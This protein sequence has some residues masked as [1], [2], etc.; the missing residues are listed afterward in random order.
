MGPFMERYGTEK[1]LALSKDAF[2]ECSKTALAASARGVSD[3]LC[4][5]PPPQ[6]TSRR[7]PQRWLPHPAQ[8][9]FC[10]CLNFVA[11]QVAS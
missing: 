9:A 5:F 6:G 8:S 4:C 2:A 11:N 3:G 1:K 7:L 10:R